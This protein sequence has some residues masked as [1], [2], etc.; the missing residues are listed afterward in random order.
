VVAARALYRILT[1]EDST[2]IGAFVT[3]PSCSYLNK[4]AQKFS[5]ERKLG[6]GGSEIGLNQHGMNEN[7]W[8]MQ[9]SALTFIAMQE[10][11][12]QSSR[13]SGSR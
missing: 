10:D 8:C 6:R 11:A 4:A 13:N 9:F 3:L 7:G 1:R 2:Q 12:D 5:T